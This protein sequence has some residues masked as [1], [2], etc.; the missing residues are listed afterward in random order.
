MWR[1]WALECGEPPCLC[2]LRSW[3]QVA[4]KQAA[5]RALHVYVYVYVYGCVACTCVRVRVYSRH[6]KRHSPGDTDYTL[7]L[8]RTVHGGTGCVYS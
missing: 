6:F 8:N 1:I 7:Q 3:T 2:V 5:R 4:P